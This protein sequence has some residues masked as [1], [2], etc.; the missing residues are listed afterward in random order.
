MQLAAA[1]RIPLDDR[2]GF[3]LAGGPAG[4]PA[5]G[6]VAFMH[7]AS[8]VENPIAPLGHPRPA[9]DPGRDHPIRD[10]GRIERVMAGYGA[11]AA[12]ETTRHAVF[13]EATRKAGKTAVFGR[14]EIVQVETDVLLHGG[15]H[16]SHD[17]GS[18]KDAV[19][20]FTLGGLREVA[21]PGTNQ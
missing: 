11:N 12:H 20:A 10:V 15:H 1:W 19:G 17:A 6:P 8:A 13:G 14:A 3:T 5:L 2:T 4:E 21:M 7:R 16:G 18:L 9:I